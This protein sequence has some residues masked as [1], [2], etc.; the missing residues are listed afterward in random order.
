[1]KRLFSLSSTKSSRASS[2]RKLGTPSDKQCSSLKRHNLVSP[3][4]SIDSQGKNKDNLA[5]TAEMVVD[6]HGSDKRFSEAN[7]EIEGKKTRQTSDM[8]QKSPADLKNHNEILSGPLPKDADRDAKDPM[9]LFA[10]RESSAVPLSCEGNCELS[11]ETSEDQQINEETP[12]YLHRQSDRK[13]S[14]SQQIPVEEQ[15][16]QEK[17]VCPNIS[18]KRNNDTGIPAWNLNVVSMSGETQP[19]FLSHKGDRYSTEKNKKII[20]SCQNNEHQLQHI[21]EE[22]LVPQS[23]RTNNSDDESNALGD[24]SDTRF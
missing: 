24:K 11:C 14:S 23:Q 13:D 17:L 3:Q 15:D 20:S 4:E 22:N 5:G 16:N 6:R 18:D 19:T 8:A 21:D 12:R 2:D 7:K 10:S 9:R 1:M